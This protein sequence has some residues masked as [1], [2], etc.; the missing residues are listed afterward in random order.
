MA[1]SGFST[2]P[3]VELIKQFCHNNVYGTQIIWMIVSVWLISYMLMYDI[4]MYDIDSHCFF[5]MNIYLWFLVGW[6]LEPHR[7]CSSQHSWGWPGWGSFADR[8]STAC[9]RA[10]SHCQRTVAASCM[11]PLS[12]APIP[13]PCSE[14]WSCF[15][16]GYAAAGAH[17]PLMP[18]RAWQTPHR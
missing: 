11:H 9:R 8:S 10:I 4:F 12:Q 15:C 18:C 1:Q 3:F 7:W 6:L 16:Q 14:A 5:I 13:G 17:T 2:E